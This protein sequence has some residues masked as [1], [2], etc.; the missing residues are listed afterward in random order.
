MPARFALRNANPNPFNPTT[1]I[2]YDLPENADVKLIVYNLLGREVI[3]LAEGNMPPGYHA[4]VWHGRDTAGRAVP[5]G[6]YIARLA[7]LKYTKSI[8][9]ILLK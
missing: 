8:K 3:R 9:M 6:L 4:A 7:T 1:T 2:R 5:S